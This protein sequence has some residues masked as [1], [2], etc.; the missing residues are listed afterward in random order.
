MFFFWSPLWD[1]VSVVEDE[2]ERNPEIE[3]E[4]C[5]KKLKGLKA[6]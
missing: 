2:E 5:W 4:R 1:Q 6:S 3:R